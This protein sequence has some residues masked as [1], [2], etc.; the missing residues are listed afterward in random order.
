MEQSNL[1]QQAAQLAMEQSHP[2]Q[3]GLH[4]GEKALLEVAAGVMVDSLRDGEGQIGHELL[5]GLP[6][7]DRLR[8]LHDAMM[9]WLIPETGELVD[10]D[11]VS[12]ELVADALFQWIQDEVMEEIAAEETCDDCRERESGMTSMRSIVRAAFE[13]AGGQLWTRD[14]QQ[15]AYK[16]A[17]QALAKR[18]SQVLIAATANRGLPACE[19]SNSNRAMPGD[20]S[21]EAMLLRKLLLL[22]SIE[23]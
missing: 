18:T 4:R 10:V 13:D 6:Y 3:Q 23:R 8:C 17:I 2:V 16:R 5:D 19:D 22:T 11:F 21:L 9:T 15:R 14:E 1:G 12:A 7:V 20:C